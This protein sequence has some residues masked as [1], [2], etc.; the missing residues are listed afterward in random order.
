MTHA[1]FNLEQIHDEQIA[2]LMAKIIE[3]CRENHMPM[4]ATFNYA[5]GNGDDENGDAFS[6]TYMHDGREPRC[7]R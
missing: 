3:I 4:L 2:P 1:P 6:T 5:H 7:A